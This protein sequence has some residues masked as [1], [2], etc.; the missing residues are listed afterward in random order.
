[1][2]DNPPVFASRVRSRLALSEASRFWLIGLAI[3]LLGVVARVAIGPLLIDDAY[4]YFRYA[5]NAAAG[6]GL[7]YNPG[8][9]VFGATSPPYTLIL[10]LAAIAGLNLIPA[11]VIFGIVLDFASSMIL[12]AVGR[13]VGTNFTGWLSALLFS[14]APKAVIP[15]LSGMET[16]F[17]TL[18]VTLCLAGLVFR[19]QSAAIVLAGLAGATR[20]EGLALLGVVVAYAALEERRVRWRATLVAALPTMLWLVLSR[21]MYHA[22]IPNSINAKAIVFPR[23]PNPFHDSILILRY[24]TNPFEFTS[25]EPELGWINLVV[26]C[27]GGIGLISLVRRSRAVRPFVLWCAIIGMAYALV[28]RSMFP[29][30][31][32]PFFP[33][34][35]IVLAFALGEI[36]GFR[37]GTSRLGRVIPHA[38]GALEAS[39]LLAFG[40]L[41]WTGSVATGNVV[42]LDQD[43]RE[44]TYLR[45]GEWLATHLPSDTTVASA[46]IGAVSYGY[47]GP[48]LDLT[49]LVSPEVLPYYSDPG[50]EFHYPHSLPA[51]AVEQL[52]PPV[53][54]TYDKFIADYS[55]ASWF[56]RAYPNVRILETGHPVYGTLMV[57]SAAGVPL[58]PP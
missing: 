18:L 11:S 15:G 13:R 14:L 28:N 45:L 30:Y 51:A 21:L 40:V 8:Q 10:T 23:Y 52:A 20:P 27:V 3:C 43:H 24:L 12:L 49:G 58:P 1:M 41:L 26:L 31:L 56:R 4:I 33:L 39:V 50:F 36:P 6:K 34:S 54:V 25:T 35:S 53:L 29:W 47:R 57:F 19:R 9:M 5:L 7:V 46:E 16:S 17:F 22:W 32:G 38:A 55:K 2:T 37:E 44:R 42:R 48:V